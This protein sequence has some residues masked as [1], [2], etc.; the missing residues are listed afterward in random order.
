[1]SY[2]AWERSVAAGMREDPLWG[3]RVYRAALYAGELGRRDAA[4]LARRP[5]CRVFAGQLARA[6]AS[7]SANIAEG[8]SRRGRRDR[9]RFYEY[10][11]GSAR[12]SRDWY[13][14]ARDELGPDASNAR[15]ALHTSIVRIMTVLVRNCRPTIPT[16]AA[17]PEPRRVPARDARVH[18]PHAEP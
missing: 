3:L 14:K 4:W 12:E 13:Y 8:Y 18:A 16:A 5:D 6:A 10:A 1:L 7:I 2:E 9:G 17:A 11:L 15:I